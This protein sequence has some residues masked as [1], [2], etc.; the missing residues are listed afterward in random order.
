[1]TQKTAESPQ[2]A[3]NDLLSLI[4]SHEKTVKDIRENKLRPA[5][6]ALKK[7]KQHYAEK[8]CFCTV[9]D[10]IQKGEEPPLIVSKILYSYRGFSIRAFKIKKNGDPYANDGEVW[11]FSNKWDDWSIVR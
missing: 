3:L 6:E 9:G 2:S 10:R 1:M 11:N 8:L 7:A 5:E 4:K